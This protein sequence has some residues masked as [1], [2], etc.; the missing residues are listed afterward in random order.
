MKTTYLNLPYKARYFQI[1]SLNE[2]T[3]HLWFVCHGYGQLG[4]S[5]LNKFKFMDNGENCIVAPEGLNRFYL[6]GFSGKVGA[7]WMTREDRLTDIE[8]YMN[9]LQLIYDQILTDPPQGDFKISILGFS[10]GVATISRWVTQSDCHFD[11]LF[12]W[13]GIFPPDLN[14]DFSQSKLKGKEIFLIYGNQD[15][16]LTEEHSTRL[17]EAIARLQ[18][19]PQKITFEGGHELHPST[20]LQFI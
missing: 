9:Y 13:A 2:N 3:K 10:Q 6:E 7:T 20:L 5:F 14:F 11:R 12:L 1:G 19:T 8:N 4:E 17:E 16:F 18:I 15:P